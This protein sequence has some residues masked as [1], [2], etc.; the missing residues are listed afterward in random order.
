MADYQAYK[1]TIKEWI[2]SC[3]LKRFLQ[4]TKNRVPLNLCD[5]STVVPLAC[6]LLYFNAFKKKLSID[7]YFEDII[8]N[9]LNQDGKIH[10]KRRLWTGGTIKEM[11]ALKLNNEY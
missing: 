7:G 2:T 11:K 6:H 5:D 1:C 8:P 4:L 9:S 10:F 3:N